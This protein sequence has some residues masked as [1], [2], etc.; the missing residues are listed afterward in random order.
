MSHQLIHSSGS[1]I[2]TTHLKGK[3]IIQDG[4]IN[5]NRVPIVTPNKD[6]L[7]SVGVR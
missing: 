4:V 7:V 1:A 2:D 3:V 6:V 5:F